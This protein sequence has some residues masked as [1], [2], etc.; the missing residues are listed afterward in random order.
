VRSSVFWALVR[1]D[2]YILRVFS[3]AGLLTGLAALGIMLTGKVGS[4]VGGILYLTVNI[5]TGIM[6]GMYAFVADRKEQSRV[7]SLSLPI[8]G[9]R[10]ELAKLV[11]AFA[12]YGIPWAI[13]TAVAV[14]VLPLCGAIPKGL[15][16]YGLLIQ[17]CCLALFSLL[18]ACLLVAKTEVLA[19]LTI[20]TTNILF[21]LFMVTLSQPSV[22]DPLKGPNIVW[23]GTAL[24][25]LA[26]ELGLIAVAL[27]FAVSIIVRKRDH[28]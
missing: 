25:L 10:H 7:F 22:G 23:T 18:I 14:L 8:S 5:A 20:I 2:V 26:G 1:K 28:L 19:A 11:A 21:S 3:I 27:I 12:S 24:G 9:Q 4:A 13:L 6:I 17:G 16:V 15:M